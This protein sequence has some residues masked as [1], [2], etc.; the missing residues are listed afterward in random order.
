MGSLRHAVLA[1]AATAC[2]AACSKPLSAPPL[3]RATIVRSFADE[4]P[5]RTTVS[6][7]RYRHAL[8]S[9]QGLPVD[10]PGAYSFDVTIPAESTIRFRPVMHPAARA[11]WEEGPYLRVVLKQSETDLELWSGEP[12]SPWLRLLQQAVI[13][14]LLPWYSPRNL[15]PAEISLPVP[16]TGRAVLRFEATGKRKACELDGWYAKNGG[17]AISEAAV[18]GMPVLQSPE[19]GDRP[20]VIVVV[21]DTLRAD[22]LAA[23]GGPVNAPNFR[24]LSQDAVRFDRALTTFPMT[25][26]STF[27][28]MTGLHPAQLGVPFWR[29]PLRAEERKIAAARAEESGLARQARRNGLRSVFAGNNGFLTDT[30]PVGYDGDWGEVRFFYKEPLDVEQTVRTFE[31]WANDPMRLFAYVHFNQPHWPHVAD[32]AFAAQGA[33]PFPAE[34]VSEVLSADDALGR[35][36]KALL[37]NKRFD[38]SL[39]VVTADHGELFPRNEKAGH[40]T[41][42]RKEELHV[43]LFIRFPHG[44][45]GGRAITDTVSLADIA[46]TIREALGW[47]AK[48]AYGRSLMPLIRGDFA[49]LPPRVLGWEGKNIDGFTDG[50]R[51]YT[52]HHA[53]YRPMDGISAGPVEQAWRWPQGVTTTV[54]ETPK[55]AD[56]ETLGRLEDEWHTL[57][58]AAWNELA[59]AP[60]DPPAPARPVYVFRGIPATALASEPAGALRPVTAD[61]DT[62]SYRLV[63]PSAVIRMKAAG[64]VWLGRWGLPFGGDMPV[65][66]TD[67]ERRLM[68]GKP[69]QAGPAAWIDQPSEDGG[70]MSAGV[71]DALRGWGYVK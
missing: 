50:V 2:V 61:A 10:A 67:T 19:Y 21:L 4:V 8:A 22:A 69:P 35:V 62:A 26:E 36:I 41:T 44:M 64:P 11:C 59:G 20:D 56:R 5:A 9:V 55:P 28:L 33:G 1:V 30:V 48:P 7:G 25:R 6:I 17:H 46:P 42:L 51:F 3:S 27:S 14:R 60:G 45:Y 58:K 70:P 54:A 68:F 57:R 63:P 24:R 12:E 52:A 37:K 23:Y 16:V 38:K 66:R 32:P 15:L 47:Q 43:P 39:I 13:S 18:W 65:I 34:Y 31:S 29:W 49:A 71:R 40:G 53:G